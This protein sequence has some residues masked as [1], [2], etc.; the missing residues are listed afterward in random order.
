[1]RFRGWIWLGVLTLGLTRPAIAQ[2]DSKAAAVSAFDEA[3]RLIEKKQ[4]ADAC[5]K[6]G[7]SQRLDPQLGTLLHWADCLERN[8]QT[9]SAWARFRDASEVA[10]ARKDRRQSLADER[11]AKLLPHLSKL[12]IQVDQ[13]ND[14]D[15]LSIQRDRVVV[16]RALW[17]T[18]TP[19]DPGA[20]SLSATAPGRK[21]W[22][23]KV[24]VPADGS[25]TILNVPEL[26]PSPSA[27]TSTSTPTGESRPPLTAEP[28]PAAD[29]GWVSRRWPVL[30]AAGVGVVGIGVGTAF[31]LKSKQNHDDA[32]EYCDGRECDDPRGVTLKQQ[33]ITD[34]NISTIV[35]AVGGLGLATAGVLLFALPSKSESGART[36]SAK[37][38]ASRA[39]IVLG[40]A[41]VGLRGTF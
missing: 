21:P 36:G 30:V 41:A 27:P 14:L 29:D 24:V 25:T 1:M 7:E 10:A 26:E 32:E 19:V 17:G 3:R 34:G 28:G 2:E 38:P 12:E 18:A 31:G 22:T 11:A 33:A 35:F 13:S 16:G 20:H 5:Q 37:A 9:A 6:F 40:P 39:A 15:Q 4:I 8:G 23:Q